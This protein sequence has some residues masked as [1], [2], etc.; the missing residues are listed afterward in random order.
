MDMK[1]LEHLKKQVAYYIKKS[2]QT[3]K[4]IVTYRDGSGTID[5]NYYIKN[6]QEKGM[7]HWVSPFLFGIIH[8]SYEYLESENIKGY[9]FIQASGSTADIIIIY[10]KSAFEE[11]SGAQL[12]TLEL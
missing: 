8:V 1:K 3:F 6:F 2:D 10:H 12:F 7:E 5:Y 9:V 4:S 11:V